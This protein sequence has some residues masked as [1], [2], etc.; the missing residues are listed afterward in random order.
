MAIAENIGSHRFSIQTGKGV[1]SATSQYGMYIAGGSQVGV[2]GT[3]APFE[4]STGL[5]MRS[6]RYVSERHAEGSPEFYVTP[7]TLAP[8]LYGA[9]GA[10]VTTGTED[11][12][13]HS[14]TPAASRPWLTWWRNT[15]D[16]YHE[17]SSDT[18]VNTLTLSGESG[19]PLHVA[20]D[21]HG[22]RP[23]YQDTAE[24][25]AAI[26]SAGRLIFYDGDGTLSLEGE[27]FADIRAFTLTIS[28]N[29]EL[30]PGDSLLPIDVS[31][32]ELTITLT[33]TKLA[34]TADYR[35]RLYFGSDTPANDADA[36][37][38]IM[39][40]GG[41]PSVDFKFLRSSTPERSAA[42]SMPRVIMEP[43]D[44]T[45][46]TG[47]TPLTEELSLIAL[48]PDAGDAITAVVLN[49]TETL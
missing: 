30:I 13:S 32:G 7:N 6:D 19:A 29:G 15:A 2:T 11:P 31:E 14:I 9:L 8:L 37:T 16:L 42:F 28:N 4:E 40:L 43:F 46:G 49:E 1:A 5:R 27:A 25:T 36:V 35:N 21:V 17:V 41:T 38:Q 26:A 24:V 44:V 22:L 18:K 10:Q 45:T 47:S 3:D 39:E 12:W 33:I 23:Q 48:Q 34:L 20:L